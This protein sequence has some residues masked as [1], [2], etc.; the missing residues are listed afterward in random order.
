MLQRSSIDLPF[1]LIALTAFLAGLPNYAFSVNINN[2]YTKSY[3]PL[4]N[5]T[6]ITLPINRAFIKAGDNTIH[7]MYN[8]PATMAEGGG[9]VQFDFHRLEVN[10]Q[11]TLTL[12]H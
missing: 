11:G 3:P 10:P 9:W 7:L 2:L 6:L 1:Y 8:G 4:A 5:G 12:L